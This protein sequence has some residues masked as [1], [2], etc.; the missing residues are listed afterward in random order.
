MAEPIAVPNGAERR[1]AARTALHGEPTDRGTTSALRLATFVSHGGGLV[2][3]VDDV[4]LGLAGYNGVVDH[5]FRR[6]CHRRYS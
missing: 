5:D 2:G 1:R 6:I 4:G 3:L